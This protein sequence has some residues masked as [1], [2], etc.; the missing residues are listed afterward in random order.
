MITEEEIYDI[1]ATLATGGLR[2]RAVEGQ[3]HD[4]FE[5]VFGDN[6][7]QLQRQGRKYLTDD[8]GLCW[9]CKDGSEVIL[10]IQ[11]Q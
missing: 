11:V 2:E 5:L 9:V 1:G 4:L 8:A 10:T 6:N 3:L 7:V